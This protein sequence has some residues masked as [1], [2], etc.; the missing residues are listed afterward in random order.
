MVARLARAPLPWREL[1]WVLAVVALIAGFAGFKWARAPAAG[2]GTRTHAQIVKLTPAAVSKG[3]PA[4]TLIEVAFADGRH[5]FVSLDWERAYRCRPGEK[6]D[7]FIVPAR[8]GDPDIEIDP[9]A[10]G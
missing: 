8:V 6:V 1:A 9:K 7:I 10:C 2:P 5:G 4:S 3:S